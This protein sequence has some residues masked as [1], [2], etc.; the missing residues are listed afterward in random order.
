MSFVQDLD[1]LKAQVAS[2]V[3][4]DASNLIDDFIR[5]MKESGIESR[6]LKV[7]QEIPSFTLPN[8]LGTPVSSTDLLL[9]GPLVVTFYRGSW[10]PFCNLYL[11]SLRD[12]V[13]EFREFDAQLVAISGMTPDNSLSIKEKLDLDFEV[14]SDVGL[15][16]SDRFG[17]VYDLTDQISALFGM[18]GMDYKNLYGNESFRMTMP[19]T[20][21]TDHRG[22]VVAEV[23]MD[24]RNRLDPLE[25][26]S[27]LQKL[28]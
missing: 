2:R 18:A 13:P 27:A 5:E 15:G 14:L 8:A 9:R 28:N 10:C 24:W 16:V 26:V 12:A 3:P 22:I 7:G 11:K 1:Q 6:A 17:L 20:Y 25:I 4:S 23:D 21:V 19:A